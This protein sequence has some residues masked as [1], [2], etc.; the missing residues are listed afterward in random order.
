MIWLY[1]ALFLPALLLSAPYYGFRMLRRGG[2]GLDFSHRF[3]RQN[4]LGHRSEPTGPDIQ[5]PVKHGTEYKCVA[6]GK[7]ALPK[8]HPAP[9]VGHRISTGALANGINKRNGVPFRTPDPESPILCKSRQGA[10][11]KKQ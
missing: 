2:Y 3:G 9:V 10:R 6:V 5:R 7:I 8:R 11:Q 1:R 4:D